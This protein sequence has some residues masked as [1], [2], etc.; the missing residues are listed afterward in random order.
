[1]LNTTIKYSALI[2][3]VFS[4]FWVELS[5]GFI[6]NS[7]ALQTDAFHMLADLFALIVG[8]KSHR[9]SKRDK[10]PEFS[11]GWKRIEII[12][13]FFNSTFL[14]ATCLFLTIEAINKLVDLVNDDFKNPQL[15]ENVDLVIYVAIAGLLVNMIGI[16]MFHSAHTHFHDDKNL[17]KN[18]QSSEV[19]EEAS[20]TSEVS[21]ISEE[22]KENLVNY[23]HYAVF[24]HVL[25][26]AL[27]SVV[28]IISSLVIR[29]SDF[30]YRFLVDPLAS[31][32][33]VIFIGYSSINLLSVCIKILL[34]RTP[35]SID[36]ERI[37][38]AIRN[39]QGVDDLHDLHIWSLNN[40]ITIGTV[41]V[42]IHEANTTDTIIKE[43]KNLLHRSGVHSSSIQPEYSEECLDPKCENNCQVKQCCNDTPPQ[44]V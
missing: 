9:L 21:N 25:G 17:E 23:N 13:G 29:F 16:S 43:I 39:I 5:L 41:H 31:L 1:M 8:L 35:N 11:Y 10:S 3:L 28:V 34:H 12:G 6:A 18:D 4:F 44:T 26:D 33:I 38:L 20:G 15:D 40:N 2:C 22:M 37:E 19:S 27:A 30:K 24:L 7:L 14:L 32:L 42:R 36:C